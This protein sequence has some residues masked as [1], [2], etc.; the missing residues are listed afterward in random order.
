MRPLVLGLVLLVALPALAQQ[1]ERTVGGRTYI[2]HTVE[3][4]Q[5]LFALSRHYAVPVD[6]LLEANPAAS[7]GLSIG[8]EVLVPKDAIERKEAR[9]APMLLRDG[10]LLHTV[11]KKETLFGIAQRYRVD[12]NALLSRNQGLDASAL[13]PGT[14][15]VIP[16]VQDLGDEEP[17]TL[18]AADDDAV[19]HTVAPGETLFSLGKQYELDPE[20]IKA[21]NGGLPEGLKAGAVV[22]IPVP[23]K[24]SAEPHATRADSL[25]LKAE[26]R[27][28]YL[29]PFA[30]DKNDSVSSGQ[31]D[32]TGYYDITR[33]AAQFYAGAQLALD[34]LED[35][36]LRATVKV[37][38]VGDDE[39]AW[40]PKLRDADLWDED[41]YIGPF[42]RQAAELLSR[43]P[44]DGA[45]ICPVPQ[46]NRVVLGHPQVSKAL[47]G[48]TD[49]V[50]TLVRYVALQHANDN[51]V[52]VCPEIFAEHELQDFTQR[53]LQDALLAQPHRLRDSV[54]VVRPGRKDLEPVVKRLDPQR[55]NV[56]VV[57]SDD[58]EFVFHLVQRLR[59]EIKD[60]QLIVYGL[61][62]WL[63]SESI[64]PVDL[65]A[66]RFR[67]ALSS[68]IDRTDPRTTAFVK[69]YRERF[70]NEPGEYAFLGYDV[71][72]HFGTALLVKG[73]HFPEHYNELRTQPLHLDFRMARTGP[74]NGFRNTWS[75][76]VE[77]RELGLHKLE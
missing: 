9:N 13:E 44:G 63:E 39:A 26:Y 29:L 74:E 69:A 60:H 11:A 42:H 52:L 76:V 71:T 1:P 68:F 32:R 6:A 23:P 49:Q 70:G 61:P 56:L 58:V 47:G 77:H 7:Q 22:R 19:F 10:E 51:V 12:V 36:G 66:L 16:R 18:P 24:P 31:V 55:R 27:I 4:G 15:L 20:A 67:T 57:P 17:T 46:S 40:G 37:V 73:H 75:V 35:Q 21:A 5:T 43:Q 62:S 14:T 59:P 41:L 50:A 72:L 8:Q 48:R 28:A 53:R 33:F 34:T 65:D 2:V 64:A 3:A 25:S 54:V 38:D 45:I 30:L